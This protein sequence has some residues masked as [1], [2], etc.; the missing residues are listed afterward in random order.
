[1]GFDPEAEPIK[2]EVEEIVEEE[3]KEAVKPKSIVKTKK[4]K[5]EVE[6]DYLDLG[7][8]ETIEELMVVKEL[9]TQQIRKHE[10]EKTGVTT[11]FITIEEAL[12]NIERNMRKLS[13]GL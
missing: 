8:Q 6:D 4:V 2:Q 1:M 10:D 9:P 5:K 13:G 12:T 3:V 7:T 11:N